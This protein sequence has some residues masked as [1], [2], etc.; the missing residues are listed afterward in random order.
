MNT[1]EE[2]REIK[3]LIA[4]QNIAGKVYTMTTVLTLPDGTRWLVAIRP[5]DEEPTNG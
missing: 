4:R 1:R 5:L 2:M 3:R